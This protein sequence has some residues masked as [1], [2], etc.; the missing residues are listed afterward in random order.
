MPLFRF[1]TALLLFIHV[2]KTGGSSIEAALRKMGGRPA[3]LAATTQGYARCTPQ[4]MQAEVLS[5]FVPEDFYDMRFAVVRDPQSRLVS[6]FKMRRVGR[7]QRGLA[8]LS[9]SDWVAQ[10]FKRYE[11]NPYVFDNHIRP[12]SALIP[13][14]TEVFRLED[15]LEAAVGT[16]ARRLGRAM[17]EL[18]LIRQGT[19]D[20]VLVP[21][22]TARDIAAFY[23]DDY[24]RFGYPA[25]E[26]G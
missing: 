26:R 2:P 8:A 19:T 21:A 25:P 11:R 6:E 24:A 20:P 17:P 10:T 13:E 22:E 9:F 3:L 14:R 1:D 18:P 7:K 15:G 23:R 12:Q 5:A 16:V 4:H